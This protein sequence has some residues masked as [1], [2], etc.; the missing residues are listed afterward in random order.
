MEMEVK[1]KFEPR[2]HFIYFVGSGCFNK[3]HTQN[4]YLVKA[5]ERPIISF[6]GRHGEESYHESCFTRDKSYHPNCITGI[7]LLLLLFRCIYQVQK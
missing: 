7:L 3:V 1:L 2:L 6:I 5:T 4:K